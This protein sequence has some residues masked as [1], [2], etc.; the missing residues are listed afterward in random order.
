MANLFPDNGG[1]FWGD[2]ESVAQ[3]DSNVVTFGKGW[4]FDYAQG[5]FMTTPSGRVAVANSREA[6]IE[7]C[8]KAIRTPRYR[9]VIYSRDY[10]SELED[11]L[12]SD[13]PHSVIES[14]V[15]RMV[16]ET[17][18]ADDRT[19]SVDQFSFAWIGDGCTFSC[20]VTSVQED[21]EFLESEVIEFG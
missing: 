6:W 4:K 9:H 2:E 17:L 20:Q 14:E 3:A 12:G 8:Q 16:T 19:S 21:V 13:Y 7:W 10:G 5:E 11:L 15:E 1:F 18:L